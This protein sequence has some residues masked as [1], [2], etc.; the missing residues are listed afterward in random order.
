MQFK[1]ALFIALAALAFC[2]ALLNGPLITSEMVGQW[3][4]S[5]HSASIVAAPDYLTAGAKPGV[6]AGQN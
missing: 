3:I 6:A 1:H 5:G 2:L 4:E